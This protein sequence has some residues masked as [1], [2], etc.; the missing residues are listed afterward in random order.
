[1][2]HHSTDSSDCTNLEL[3]LMTVL[4]NRAADCRCARFPNR[5]ADYV[6]DNAAV[7]EDPHES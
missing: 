7:P 4:E 2:F 1:M 3:P 6:A 5:M